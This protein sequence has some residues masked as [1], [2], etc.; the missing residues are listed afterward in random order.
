[1]QSL[2]VCVCLCMYGW[3]TSAIKC[4]SVCTACLC[5]CDMHTVCACTVVCACCAGVGWGTLS[6]QGHRQAVVCLSAPEASSCSCLPALS[7]PGRPPSQRRRQ[8]ERKL[9]LGTIVVL[10]GRMRPAGADGKESSQTQ[11]PLPSPATRRLPPAPPHFSAARRSFDHVPAGSR[12]PRAPHPLQ[13]E[14]EL[15]QELAE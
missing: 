15:P 10:R 7:F 14:G 13:N 4:V 8:A 11:T 5:L 12:M 3:R 9:T 1:M 2:C 6:H